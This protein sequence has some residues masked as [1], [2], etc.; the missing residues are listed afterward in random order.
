[1]MR[2]ASLSIFLLSELFFAI[3]LIVY[4]SSELHKIEPADD[5]GGDG[6]WTELMMLGTVSQWLFPESGLNKC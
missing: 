5:M 6:N 2:K 4:A 3:G 1:M